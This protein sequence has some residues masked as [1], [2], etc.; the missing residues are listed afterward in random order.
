[1]LDAEPEVMAIDLEQ[2]ERPLD[3]HGVSWGRDADHALVGKINDAAYGYEGSFERVLGG[4]PAGHGEWYVAQLGGEPAAVLITI[5]EGSNTDVDM[6]AT[7]PASQAQGRGHAAD[8]VTRWPTPASVAS[9][10]PPWWPRAPD[11]RS[12][13]GWAFARSD[14]SRCGSGGAG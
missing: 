3:D 6:V 2:A 5:D 1:M 10:R 12:T 11:G 8:G 14:R 13:S 7:L 9:R 4:V